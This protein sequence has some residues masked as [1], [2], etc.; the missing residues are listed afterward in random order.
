MNEINLGR[1]QGADGQTPYIGENG[2][3]FIGDIDTGVNASGGGGG[4]VDEVLRS[5][6]IGTDVAHHLMNKDGSGAIA[7][8][9]EPLG[10]LELWSSGKITLSFTY[11]VLSGNPENNGVWTFG[12]MEIEE[13]SKFLIDENGHQ[14]G[15][16]L[17]ACPMMDKIAIST[18]DSESWDPLVLTANLNRPSSDFI[19]PYMVDVPIGWPGEELTI[20]YFGYVDASLFKLNW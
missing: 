19:P 6:S 7:S 11:T 16:F 5:E 17:N 1:V 20:T 12:D 18:R 15:L 10:T 14:T 3:W 8:P 9:S 4:S 13:I 2:N